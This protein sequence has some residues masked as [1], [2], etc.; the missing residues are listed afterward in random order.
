MD[1][2]RFHREMF[3]FESMFAR[4]MEVEL[5]EGIGFTVNHDGLSLALRRGL[6][7]M[8]V[9]FYFYQAIIFD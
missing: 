9:I 5:F 6:K 8:A 1:E 3:A 4:R 2:M 7:G